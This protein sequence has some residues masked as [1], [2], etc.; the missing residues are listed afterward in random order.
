VHQN[1]EMMSKKRQNNPARHQ[2]FH[3]QSYPIKKV[4]V[5]WNSV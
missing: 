5:Q 1:K 3:G 4:C 2:F